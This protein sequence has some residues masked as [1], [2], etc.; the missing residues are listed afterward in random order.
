MSFPDIHVRHECG[1]LS[2]AMFRLADLLR[3][4]GYDVETVDDEP[5]GDGQ[6]I[7]GGDSGSPM[8][9]VNVIERARRR[10]WWPPCRWWGR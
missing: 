5:D 6:L 8:W 2:E 10:R 3:A 4:C 1:A 7:V 9:C